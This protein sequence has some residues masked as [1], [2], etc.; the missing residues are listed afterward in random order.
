MRDDE[1]AMD[2]E[3]RFYDSVDELMRD[4]EY[5][6]NVEDR[7][8]YTNIVELFANGYNIFVKRNPSDEYVDGDF[9]PMDLLELSEFYIY[10]LGS[11]GFFRRGHPYR[12]LI[13]LW[14][15]GDDVEQYDQETGKWSLVGGVPTF[16][17]SIAFR[18]ANR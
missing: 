2:V 13:L 16:D 7:L 17:P 5:S 9:Q 14:L 18:I 3:G 11:V 10:T 15:N 4:D 1:Y 8:L 12:S 6:M